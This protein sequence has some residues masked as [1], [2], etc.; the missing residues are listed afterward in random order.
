MNRWYLLLLTFLVF[1]SYTNALPNGFV[2]DDT[3]LMLHAPSWNIETLFVNPFSFLRQLTYQIIYGIGGL[4]PFLFRLPNILFHLCTVWLIFFLLLRT[5]RLTVAIM[6]ASLFAVHPI[7]VESVT[8]IS[9]GVYAQYSFFFLLSFVA[10]VI[11]ANRGKLYILSLASFALMLFSSERSIAL[12]LAFPLYELSRE[13]LRTNWKKILPYLVGSMLTVILNFVQIGQRRVY[14][15]SDSPPDQIVMNPL[16]Q[17]PIAITS[18]IELIFWP[19]KLT[20]YH[21]EMIFT[22]LEYVIRLFF[23]ILFLGLILFCYRKN[24]FLFFWLCFFM[25]FLSLTLTPLGITWIVAERYVY[26]GALGI[27]IPV[28]WVFAKVIEHRRFKTAAIAV[29]IIIVIGFSI[30]T[31]VRNVDWYNEDN[32]WLAAART[33]PSSSQNH[34]NLGDYYGRHGDLENSVRH[35]QRAIEL[36]PNYADAHHNLGNAYRNLGRLDEAV[37]QYEKAL[38]INS[39]IWQS[40]QNIAAIH[41]QQGEFDKAKVY[42]EKGILVEPN[43]PN[44]RLVQGLIYIKTNERE[45][46]RQLL[47]EILKLDPTNELAKN[48]LEELDKTEDIDKVQ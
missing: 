15:V 1:V 36:K 19:D 40:Y 28:V 43:N 47:L 30:R 21:S 32:L 26:L 42:I 16:L 9:G 12:S 39:N 48:G 7:L 23:F 11:S 3:G 45:K 46:A 33:S 22:Q 27:F 6:S 44:L 13:R 38:S 8:W 20:L 18:Y 10:Y 5:T 2:A 31:I 17:I 41:Y 34:N 29:F 25:V 24:R 35:F 37:S 14:F 4:N